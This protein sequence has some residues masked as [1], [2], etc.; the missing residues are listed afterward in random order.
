MIKI[1]LLPYPEEIKRAKTFNEL[2][3]FVGSVFILCLA[4]FFFQR[5]RV[6]IV[7]ELQENISELNAD[8]DKLKDV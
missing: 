8:I 2:T 1:N 6:N 4:L 7:T 5:S 3:I